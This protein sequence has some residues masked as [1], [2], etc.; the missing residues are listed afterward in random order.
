MVLICSLQGCQLGE[1]TQERECIVAKLS[2]TLQH[3]LRRS[4]APHSVPSSLLAYLPQL[5]PQL[6]RGRRAPPVAGVQRR[7]GRAGIDTLGAGCATR[8]DTGCCCCGA[9]GSLRDRGAGATAGRRSSSTGSRTLGDAA[10][11]RPVKERSGALAAGGRSDCRSRPCRRRRGDGK[12]GKGGSVAGRRKMTKKI[13]DMRDL[14][15]IEINAIVN[16]L[17]GLYATIVYS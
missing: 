10:Q 7:G 1:R 16:S 13:T 14:I 11:Q 2:G 6:A 4:W 5:R 9:A 15:N 3:A 12:D 8:P 17:G